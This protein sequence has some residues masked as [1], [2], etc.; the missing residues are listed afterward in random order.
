MTDPALLTDELTDLAPTGLE[1]VAHARRVR[2]D[3]WSSDST[4]A[5]PVR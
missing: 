4:E 5:S 1:V 2:G 3:Y